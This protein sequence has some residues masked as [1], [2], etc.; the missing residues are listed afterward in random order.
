MKQGIL[1]AG[2]WL[3]AQGAWAQGSPYIREIEM[4]LQQLGF[5]PGPV[6]G[7]FDSKL[8]AAINAF[9]ASRQLPQDGL[10]DSRT[11]DLLARASAPSPAPVPAPITVVQP[12]APPLVQPAPDVPIPTST[13]NPNTQPVVAATAA[14]PPVRRGRV[15]F[16]WTAGG[17]IESGGDRVGT[18]DFTNGRHKGL[19][20]GDGLVF[21]AGLRVKPNAESRWE[22]RAVGGFKYR[23]TSDA[24]SNI[25]VRRITHELS[26]RFRVA[27][28][29]W[30][31][32]GA[33]AH[34]GIYY[35]GD[36]LMPSMRF[37]TAVGP[38]VQIGWRGLLMTAT[39]MEYEE[40]GGG[41]FDASS[42]GLFA[43]FPF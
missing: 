36:N 3:A 30:L 19:P 14:K 7:Q 31:G 42:I 11:R 39:K 22:F 2:L 6:D 16:G 23:G 28:K 43:A 34:T 33:Q 20:L 12:A 32:A 40:V 4:Q 37:R 24:D 5:D 17:G 9:K 1:L 8:T 18:L 35:E 10:L 29:F 21:N 25:H 41:D 26:S 13:P 27:G 38:V 15:V